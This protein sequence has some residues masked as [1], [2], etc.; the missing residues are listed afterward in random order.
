MFNFFRKMKLKRNTKLLEVESTE[1]KFSD[2]MLVKI[3][4]ASINNEVCFGADL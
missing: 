1:Q 2:R 4:Q 3:G